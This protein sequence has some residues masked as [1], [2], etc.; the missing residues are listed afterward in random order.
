MG[1]MNRICK[2]NGITLLSYKD[3]KRVIAELGLEEQARISAGFAVHT[4]ELNFIFYDSKL[5]FWEKKQVIAHEMGHVFMGHFAP[6][7]K[8]STERLEAEAN[9]FAAVMVASELCR[10]YAT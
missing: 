10:T 1:L 9:I 6:S 2:D 8:L 4:E 7:I 5:S 3:G